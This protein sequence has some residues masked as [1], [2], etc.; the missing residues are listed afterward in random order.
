MECRRCCSSQKNTGMNELVVVGLLNV[1]K[2]TTMH[3]ATAEKKRRKKMK[4]EKNY[5]SASFRMK[6]SDAPHYVIMVCGSRVH[7]CNLFF[8]WEERGRE[9]KKNVQWSHCEKK[10]DGRS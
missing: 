5:T 10:S 4:P 2:M 8:S 9:K 6:T 3:T 7:N 1:Q